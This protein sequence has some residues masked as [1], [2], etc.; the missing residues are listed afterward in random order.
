VT[1][2]Q[3]EVEVLNALADDSER[4]FDTCLVKYNFKSDKAVSAAIDRAASAGIGIIAM[5]TQ[6]GGYDTKGWAGS[7][8]TRRPSSGRCRTRG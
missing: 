1:T 7:A 5:K 8:N 6:V 4:F 2:H 3:N